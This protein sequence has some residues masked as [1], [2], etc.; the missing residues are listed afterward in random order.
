[1]NSAFESNDLLCLDEIVDIVTTHKIGIG[2]VAGIAET[3]EANLGVVIP[4]IAG[5]VN[6]GFLKETD[7]VLRINTVRV[8]EFQVTHPHI[9]VTS[10]DSV[11]TESQLRSMIGGEK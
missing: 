3:W 10:S 4:E 2:D 9:R 11:V 8:E 7:G 5:Y 6:D 1:M